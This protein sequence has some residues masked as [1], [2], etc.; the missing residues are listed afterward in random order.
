MGSGRLL[1]A[2]V[3]AGAWRL[4]CEGAT[5]EV[6]EEPK[7]RVE[8]KK[9]MDECMEHDAMEYGEYVQG[10][11]EFHSK[12]IEAVQAPK[13]RVKRVGA[14]GARRSPWDTDEILP[15]DTY[16]QGGSFLRQG[17]VERGEPGG[18]FYS[19]VVGDKDKP[20]AGMVYIPPG[21]FLLGSLDHELEMARKRCNDCYLIDEARQREVEL[22]GFFVDVHEVTRGEYQVF[23]ED[24]VYSGNDIKVESVCEWGVCGPDRAVSEVRWAQ[25][26]AHPVKGVSVE[27]ARRYCAWAGKRL[28]KEPEWE[29]V[30]RGR[31]GKVFPWGDEGPGPTTPRYGNFS[32]ESRAPSSP[33]VRLIEGY[34]DGYAETAPVGS[35]EA[36]KTDEGVY[37][38][39]GNVAEWVEGGY[40]PG[41]DEEAGAH[42]RR[43]SCRG[44]FAIRGGSW[45]GT[46]GVLRATHRHPMNTD[47]RG[48]QDVGIRCAQSAE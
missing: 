45:L 28:L 39:A 17:G 34:D 47:S 10:S 41:R 37:D 21:P 27:D 40:P 26:Q 35:F 4:G 16:E 20:P 24:R 7:P 38:M 22:P 42:A 12:K 32:D 5:G 23:L 29:R 46:Y 2:A 1:L 19:E 8:L 9:I 25:T 36:G 44:A 14:S 3:L 30:A 31:G 13:A 33:S 6:L 48:W 18:F 43:P 11:A 15:E